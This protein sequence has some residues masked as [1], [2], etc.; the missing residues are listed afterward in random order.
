MSS[1]QL[2]HI[3]TLLLAKGLKFSIT[4]NTLPHEDTIV[5]IA[6]AVNDLTQEETDPI[7]AKISLWLQNSKPS[8]DNQ[9]KDEPKVLKELQSDTSIVVLP[10]GKGR[11]TVIFNC[12][13]YL[14]KCTHDINNGPN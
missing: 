13:G 1:W 10:A 4:S 6:D 2:A 9:S 12:E 11:S 7:R 14:E 3:E 5:T 8:K